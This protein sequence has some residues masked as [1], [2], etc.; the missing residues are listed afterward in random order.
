[1][2][3]PKNQGLIFYYRD[4][5]GGVLMAKQSILK[6]LFLLAFLL[7]DQV[8]AVDSADLLPPDQAFQFTSKVKKSDK[9]LLSWDIAGGYY[10]YRQKFKFLSLTPGITVGELSFPA[11]Q[12]KEDATFGK[13]EIFRDHIEVE[14]LLQRQEPKLDKLALEVTFQGCADIGVCYM[15]IHKPVSLDL[16]DESFNWWGTTSPPDQTT[17]FISEQNRIADSLK[18]GSVWLIILSFLGF[19][20][21][22]AFTPCIFPMLPILSGIVVGQGSKLNTRR[23]FLLSISYVLASALS[24]TG[25]GI[26]IL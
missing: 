17:P 25:I 6:F 5:F 9:L 19:G 21:L 15:P 13:V 14:V 20:L 26:K 8:F 16:S 7:A 22:L 2:N 12:P 3:L 10:L 4:L 1:M 24:Y 18:T 23:A 11:G